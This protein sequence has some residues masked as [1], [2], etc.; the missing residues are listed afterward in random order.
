MGRELRV[1]AF[2]AKSRIS[3]QILQGAVPI[4]EL[5]GRLGF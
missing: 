1:A 2:L 3:L 4:H 5:L